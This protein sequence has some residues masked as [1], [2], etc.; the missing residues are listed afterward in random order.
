MDVTDVLR[1]R[2]RE[3]GGYESM[4]ASMSLLMHGVLFAALVFA[5]GLWPN[6]GID[7]PKTVMTISLGGGPP[8]PAIG[9]M[10]AQRGRPVQAVKPPDE[11]AKPEAMRPPAARTPEMTL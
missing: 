9:G 1:D 6:R 4:A 8:G 5:P 10:T 2:M 3:P 7:I 11:A